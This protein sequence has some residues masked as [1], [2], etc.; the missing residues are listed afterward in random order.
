MNATIINALSAI[1]ILAAPSCLAAAS[2]KTN[3]REQADLS[4][5]PAVWG[6]AFPRLALQ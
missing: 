2:S 1:A 3:T 4:A 6:A 5:G